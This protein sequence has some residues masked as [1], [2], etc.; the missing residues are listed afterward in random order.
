[1][2]FLLEPVRIEISAGVV[3]YRREPGGRVELLLIKDRYGNWGLPKGHVEEGESLESAALRECRE[4]TG[5]RSLRLVKPLGT[6]DWYFRFGDTPVHKYCDFFL[7]ETDQEEVAEPQHD[8]GVHV[9]RWTS[10]GSV[11]TEVTYENARRVVQLALGELEADDGFEEPEE[12]PAVATLGRSPERLVF[13]TGGTGFVGGHVARRLVRGGHRVRALV[14]GRGPA[15]RELEGREV[16]LVEGDVTEPD[17]LSGALDGCDAAIHLV[18]IRRERPRRVTFQK[19]HVEGT[20]NVVEEAVRAGVGRYVHMSALGAKPGGTPYHR[21]KYEAEEEVRSRPITHVIFRP[22]I[23]AGPDSEFVAMLA[24]MVRFSPIVPVLGSGE[25][26]LQPVD[27][28]DVAEVFVQ[29]VER[30][31]IQDE[32]YE[33]GGPHKLTYNRVLEIVGE[34]LAGPRPKLHVPLGLVRPLID[35]AT[36]WRLPTPITSGELQ[37]LVEENVVRGGGNAIREVFGFDPT[38]FRSVLQQMGDGP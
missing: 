30:E 38:P 35:L 17:S 36:R 2:K 13:L 25:Y 6:I 32:T 34:E 9:C 28:R 31:D 24:R 22:S 3:V 37:M 7:V 4:E 15:A 23:I 29:A 18:G 27:V 20:R 1:M 5:L 12:A 10:P 8:E 16:E 26:R 33:L 21:T 11:L 14:R 19:I